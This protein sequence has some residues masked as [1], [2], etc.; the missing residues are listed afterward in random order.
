MRCGTRSTVAWSHRRRRWSASGSYRLK[1]SIGGAESASRVLRA[2]VDVRLRNVAATGV[3]RVLARFSDPRKDCNLRALVEGRFATRA[4]Q[5][6]AEALPRDA[7]ALGNSTLAVSHGRRPRAWAWP[8]RINGE[9]HATNDERS[10][11]RA[12]R[13]L[14]NREVGKDRDPRR[15]TAERVAATDACSAARARWGVA[16]I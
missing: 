1:L 9:H 5:L 14:L 13:V 16:A 6:P 12:Q 15:S 7:Y 10:G 11:G 2:R 4:R 8:L 3:P